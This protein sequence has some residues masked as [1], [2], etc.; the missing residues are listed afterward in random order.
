MAPP[1]PSPVVAYG[2]S[3]AALNFLARKLHFENDDL[4]KLASGASL[5]D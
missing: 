1:L 2:V 5:V 4:G 3:K